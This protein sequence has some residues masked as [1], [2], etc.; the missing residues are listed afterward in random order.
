ML[1]VELK[2]SHTDDT[3]DQFLVVAVVDHRTH[4]AVELLPVAVV[5]FDTNIVAGLSPMVANRTA[6]TAAVDHLAEAADS[7]HTDIVVDNLL[8]AVVS[9]HEKIQQRKLHLLH[10]Q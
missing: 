5:G 1:A 4:T 10:F 3:D 8:V 6:D 9:L 2:G 7:F